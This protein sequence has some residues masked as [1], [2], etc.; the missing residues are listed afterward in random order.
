MQQAQNLVSKATAAL[1]D[2][3]KQAAS[4]LGHGTALSAAPTELQQVNI[5]ED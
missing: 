1:S 5:I 4:W 2:S 3:I